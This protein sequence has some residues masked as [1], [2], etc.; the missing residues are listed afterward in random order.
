MEKGDWEVFEKEERKQSPFPFPPTIFPQTYR[1]PYFSRRLP[2]VVFAQAPRITSKRL[3]APTRAEAPCREDRRSLSCCPRRG[4]QPLR[5]SQSPA[6]GRS[7]TAGV[8]LESC[9]LERPAGDVCKRPRLL[10]GVDSCSSLFKRAPSALF[11]PRRGGGEGGE[12]GWGSTSR[13]LLSAFALPSFLLKF[14]ILLMKSWSN[15]T[16]YVCA[17]VCVGGRF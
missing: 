10:A 11:T 12:R 13:A 15:S 7:V 14:N 9:R 2:F 8:W 6:G 16:L 3:H 5:R 1:F 17:C 4:R